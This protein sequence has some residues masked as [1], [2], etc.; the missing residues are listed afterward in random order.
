MELTMQDKLMS[1]VKG[2][3][4]CV[5]KR[6]LRYV[7]EIKKSCPLITYDLWSFKKN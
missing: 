3:Y 6:K 7:K 5:Q 2:L 1:V 4:L